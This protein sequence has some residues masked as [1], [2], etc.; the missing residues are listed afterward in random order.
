MCTIFVLTGCQ[1][2]KAADLQE[3]D[4]RR[5]LTT[6]ADIAHAAYA[7][8]VSE[9]RALNEAVDVLLATPTAARG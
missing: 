6:Y 8:A 3:P 4:A 1:R 9:A 7:D 2:L 5:A